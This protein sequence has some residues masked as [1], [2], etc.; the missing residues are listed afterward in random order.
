LR[1]Y[2]LI[3]NPLT[4]SFSKKHFTQKFEKE[5]IKDAAYH[6][7]PLENIQELPSL[8]S[9]QPNLLGLNV[10]IPYKAQVI[11]FLDEIDEVSKAIG[12]VNV[13]KVERSD[14]NKTV[15]RGFNTDVIGFEQSLKPLLKNRHQK[16]LILGSGGAAHSVMYVIKKLSIDPT[17]VSKTQGHIGDIEVITYESIN[18]GLL[19]SN[20]LIVNCTPL[21]MYPNIHEYPALPY[22]HLSSRHLLYDLV[23]NPEESKFLKRGKQHGAMIKNG[24]EMLEIQ[25]ER[26]WEIWNAAKE[27]VYENS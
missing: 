3:G 17:I 21:G 14:P 26:S 7:F 16:A 9:S 24:L 10:T 22:E 15:L 8:F 5:N 18:E 27:S 1:D 11:S 2:G 13:I 6:L 20:T 23:Y 19:E 4:H 25:A 12:A